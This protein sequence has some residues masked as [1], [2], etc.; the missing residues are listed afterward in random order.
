M[1]AAMHVVYL[2]KRLA[3]LQPCV[4]LISGSLW[5]S[6]S[7]S[8]ATVDDLLT[9]VNRALT[10]DEISEPGNPARAQAIASLLTENLG[11]SLADMTILRVAGAEAWIDAGQANESEALLAQVFAQ[12]ELPD[13]VQERA[14]LALVAAWHLRMTQPAAEPDIKQPRRSIFEL[15]AEKNIRHPLVLARAHIAQA[16]LLQLIMPDLRRALPPP[17]ENTAEQK[18][19]EPAPETPAHAEFQRVV[20]AY[21]Q[22]VD[23]ALEILREHPA[24][25]RVPVYA[26]RVLGME[27]GG[28]TGE[29]VEKWLAAR[30][31]DPAAQ[32]LLA[33]VISA[34]E[35]F[36]GQ[37]APALKA[38]RLDGKDG[39]IDLAEYAGKTVVID[40]FATW[41]KP[42]EAVAPIIAGAAAHLEKE[43]IITIG[44]SLDTK[45]TLAN[46]PAWIAKAGINYPIIGEGIGWDSEI[47]DA[48]RVDGVPAVIVVGPDGRILANER[49]IMGNTAAETALNVL[50]LLKA[51]PR[52]GVKSE[53]P[54]KNNQE[55][56]AAS[57]G[58]IP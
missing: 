32:Q 11:L 5:W 27:E 37:K 58:F 19:S 55:Q 25:E 10:P 36:L 6:A 53:M 16:R 43:G 41:C 17:P 4:W 20:Q 12:P 33:S 26:M 8:A 7:I 38:K 30:A 3:C 13:A 46:L 34:T 2:A 40:F 57:P 42:C 56:P 9:E 49:Q 39:V 28:Q 50:K 48:W 15:L 1:I 45:E 31:P 51:Q 22:H 54:A 35:K 21:L 44:V 52:E 23:T 29:V 24:P 47:D 14:G 18:N